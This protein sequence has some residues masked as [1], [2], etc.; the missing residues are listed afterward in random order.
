MQY[1]GN[2]PKIIL[3]L[4]FAF[5]IFLPPFMF[6]A[7]SDRTVSA[8]E[9]RMLARKPT[10]PK[11][12]DSLLSF[13]GNVEKYYN[14]H[15]GLRNHFIKAHVSVRRWLTDLTGINLFDNVLG[16]RILKGK[17]GWIFLNKIDG[18]PLADY[19]N[20]ELYSRKELWQATISFA[21]RKHWLAERKIQYLLFFA[22][23]KHT[24]YPEYLPDY[25][26][27][28]G[29]RSSMDQLYDSL[30]RYTTV[31]FV[32]LRKHLIRNKSKASVYWP[33]EKDKA[34]LYWK[35]DSHWNSAGAD[36]AQYA[37]AREIEKMLPGALV[38]GKR[39]REDFLYTTGRGDLTRYLDAKA[40]YDEKVPTILNG[41]CADATQSEYRRR[42]Q[43]TVCDQGT[44]TAVIFHDS[45][46]LA[47]KPF[48]ADYFAR[49]VFC[50]EPL[51]QEGMLQKI[52]R[53]DPALVI[54]EHAERFLPFIPEIK[55]EVYTS[56]WEANYEKWDELI[57]RL[58]RDNISALSGLKI[59]D[60]VNGVDTE[61]DAIGLHATGRDPQLYMEAVPFAAEKLYLLKIDIASPADTQLQIFSSRRGEEDLYPSEA[62]SVVFPLHKG[63][64]TVYMP[65]FSGNMGKKIRL[66]PG[67]E[68]GEYLIKRFEIRGAK[69]LSSKGVWQ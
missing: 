25:I 54:E 38:P 10:I 51:T 68:P 37:I 27:K 2:I 16:G 44:I 42:F 17:D 8:A 32:D 43:Q 33:E 11:D 13:P 53:H 52:E 55:D 67:M 66:D 48:M 56:F 29:D 58:D 18:D 60:T 28:N 39:P 46:F 36:I 41:R 31:S 22:P 30:A 57:F 15:F 6:L 49:T 20:L 64:N 5:S 45:F 63:D 26:G 12:F 24:V 47:L 19:R 61:E 65:L 7:Q 23:D 35:T 1:S 4:I 69:D 9:N 59:R 62:L 14:D 3:L 50:W 40:I 34:R 21:A